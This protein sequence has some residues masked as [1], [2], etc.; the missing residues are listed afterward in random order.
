MEKLRALICARRTADPDPGRPDTEISVKRPDLLN[1]GSSDTEIPEKSPDML[2]TPSTEGVEILRMTGFP[3]ERIMGLFGV[4]EDT[5]PQDK[6][7]RA[8][9]TLMPDFLSRFSELTICLL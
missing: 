2:K 7:W 5:T 4:Q 1:P 3:V 9:L 8:D 6:I